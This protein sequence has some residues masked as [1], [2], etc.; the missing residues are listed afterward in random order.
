MDDYEDA[1]WTASPVVFVSPTYRVSE[2]L[3][4]TGEPLLVSR[5]RPKLG[6]DLTPRSKKS[7]SMGKSKYDR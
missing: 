4:V 6:F 1:G 7:K 3:D 2:L 5:A